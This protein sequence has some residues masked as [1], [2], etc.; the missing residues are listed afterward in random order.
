MAN[1]KITDLTAITL[2]DSADLIAIVD[3]PAGTPVTKKITHEDLF[4]LADG[5]GLNDD[6][7][8]EVLSVKKTA[9]AVNEI[10]ITNA[11]TGNAPDISATGDNTDIDI[12]LTPKGTGG[13]AVNTGDFT[14]GTTSA[15]D[16]Q[17]ALKIIGDA[18][19]DAGGDT[20]DTLQ[21]KLTPNATPTSATWNFTST[22]SA[23]YVFDKDIS[24]NNLS[25]TN[26]GDEAA[27][28]ESVAGVIE[29]ATDAEMTTGTATD[30]AITPANAK[31]ELDKKS[32]IAGSSSIVTVGA[33]NAGSITSGFGTIDNGASNIT[34]TGTAALGAITLGVDGTVAAMTLSEKTSIALDPAGGADGDFS[35]IT[36][37]GTAGA[38]VAFGEF[39][40]LDSADSEW[41]L[42]DADAVATAG[43]VAVA[44]VVVAGTDGNPVTLMTHGIIR[45]DAV[46]PTLT[47]GAAAYLGTTPGAVQVAEPTGAD[48][49][50]RVMGFALTANELMVTISP[51]HS[52]VTG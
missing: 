51:S 41:K 36:F 3:D 13:V 32:L 20:D 43:D 9:T 24:A 35:G 26:T 1:Q 4:S 14:V 49:V 2:A 44:V 52:T 6:A 12:T 40:F 45:A 47:I 28:S 19:S 37:T 31:V 50:V 7:G 11:A 38:T 8:L 18:D 30:R 33:V 17:P 21:I 16:V 25:G 46:F 48:D 42:T 5:K 10:T 34:T 27:A 22:Q 39:V 15:D 29:L 23:G